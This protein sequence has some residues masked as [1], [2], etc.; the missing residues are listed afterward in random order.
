[1]TLNKK[2]VLAFIAVTALPFAVLVWVLSIPAIHQSEV[3]T[4][5]RLQDNVVQAARFIDQFMVSCVRDMKSFASNTSYLNEDTTE[6]NR[7]LAKLTHYY[8]YFSEM[9]FIDPAGKIAASSYSPFVGKALADMFDKRPDKFQQATHG[10]PGSVFISDLSDVSERVH[11]LA[12]SGE[13]TQAHLKLQLLAPVHDNSGRYLGTLIADLATNQLEDL[14][15]DVRHRMPGDDHVYLLDNAGRVL[16]STDPDAK[17]LLAH[18]DAQSIFAPEVAAGSKG[19]LTYTDAQG[20]KSMTGYASLWTHGVDQSDRWQLVASAPYAVIMQPVV[21]AY[22]RAGAILL[23]ALMIAVLVGAF[24]ARVLA[25]PILSLTKTAQDIAGCHF[26]ARAVVNTKDETGA[27]ATA[28]NEMAGTLQRQ[29]GALEES[30]DALERRVEERTRALQQEISE[31][32][33]S[34][35]ALRISNRRFELMVTATTNVIWDWDL[36][37]SAVWWNDNFRLVFGYPTEEIGDTADSWTSRIHPDDLPRILDSIHK[38]ID[39]DGTLWFDE[40]RFRRHDGTYAVVLDRGYVSRDSAG[41]ATSMIGAMQDVSRH[42]K[43]LDD[44]EKLHRQ[45]LDA[46]R[47]GGMAEIASNV[48]HNVGNVL[49]SANVSATL[50][51]DR[52]RRSKAT[53]LAKVVS[54]LQEHEADLG[55]FIT[56]DARGKHLPTYLAELSTQ[57]QIEQ[58]DALK[59]IEALRQNIDHI[60][61]IVT[62]QQSYATMSGVKEVLNPV[63]LIEDS[64][65]MNAGALTR[66]GVTVE[67][68]FAPVPEINVDKHR[69]LQILVNLVRNAKY[70]CDESDRENKVLTLRLRST[71]NRLKIIVCDNGVGIPPENLTRI[72]NHGF[73]TRPNGHGFGLHSGALA[74][75]ELGGSLIAESAG[76]GQGATFTLELPFDE[77]GKAS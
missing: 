69:V 62:M 68:D 14:L 23:T 19:Y 70:A 46:S 56:S 71:A 27:L 24:L 7:Q 74:A 63:D 33:R 43:A 61:E 55:T 52:I 1:M 35:S 39:H 64:L 51:S 76:V 77:P 31:R 34:E 59:E 32:E 5:A 53:N 36:A 72:F 60:K 11:A 2:L 54:L 40:Y 26:D 50:V 75:Q 18:P 42:K 67:R 28:F 20:H 58:Q 44:L 66:H 6:N 15:Q 25:R 22:Q 3:L 41:K 17:L 47:R 57:V 12:A 73:T 29:L 38:V 65:R 13:V 16:I 48:L 8:P 30:R 21:V 9:S 45:L 49:N 4:G 10:A 37:T